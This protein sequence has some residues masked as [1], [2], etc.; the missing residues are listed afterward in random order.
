[1]KSSAQ[2]CP[3]VAGRDLEVAKLR[4]EGGLSISKG[5]LGEPLYGH[6]RRHSMLELIS[7]YDRKEE[8]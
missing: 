8:S 2:R 5:L 1:M 3:L 4:G 6:S 7:T